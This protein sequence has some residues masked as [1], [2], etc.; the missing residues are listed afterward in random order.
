MIFLRHSAKV[1][2]LI[3]LLFSNL[4]AQDSIYRLEAGTKIRVKM[5]VEINSGVSS[6]N[7]TFTVRIARP[8]KSGDTVLLPEGTLIEGRVIES[9]PASNAGRPGSMLIRFERIKPDGA[10]WQRMDAVP[11]KQLRGNSTANWSAFSII[12]GTAIGA[13]IGGLTGS[14]KGALIGAGIGAGGGSAVA[15][16][17]KGKDVRIKSGDVFEIVLKEAI[18]LPVRD[19]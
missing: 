9:T 3:L 8:V 6:K 14:G 19:F 18:V 17:R 4:F 10:D 2:A 15:Y 7:D 5:D 12:G 11:V 1:F 13:L 16:A